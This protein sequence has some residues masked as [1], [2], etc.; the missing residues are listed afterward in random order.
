MSIRLSTT[1]RRRSELRAWGGSAA[2]FA[3]LAIAIAA[4]GLCSGAAAAA[5]ESSLPGT[6]L[7]SNADFDTGITGWTSHTFPPNEAAARG[8]TAAMKWLPDRDSQGSSSSGS[9]EFVISADQGRCINASQ[10]V[11]VRPGGYELTGAAFIHAT[12]VHTR[13]AVSKLEVLWIDRPDC[14]WSTT[15]L[16]QADA[17]PVLDPTLAAVE[18]E[19]WTPLGTGPITA[20]EGTQGAQIEIVACVSGAATSLETVIIDFDH[21]GFR[22]TPPP[23]SDP[24]KP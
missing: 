23:V 6:N 1:F 9:I 7:I 2:M 8:W 17:K 24:P 19:K 16:G 18:K 13:G 10:C 3:Q 14:V 21:L 4:A 11:A 12:D 20:P 5:E 15:A 22:A